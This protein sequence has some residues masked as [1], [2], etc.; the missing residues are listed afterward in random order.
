MSCLLRVSHIVL[1]TL[2][3][4]CKDNIHTQKYWWEFVLHAVVTM[5][6]N[7]LNEV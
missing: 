7:W 3:V 4:K 2:L 6:N 5:Y 1:K